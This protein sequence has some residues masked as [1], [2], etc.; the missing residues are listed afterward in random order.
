MIR[1]AVQPQ[2][3][4]RRHGLWVRAAILLLLMYAILQQ[5]GSTLQQYHYSVL[6]LMLPQSQAELQEEHQEHQINENTNEKNRARYDSTLDIPEGSTL[7]MVE[8]R[9]LG[10]FRNQQMRLAGLVV[11]ALQNNHSSI[12]LESIRYDNPVAREQAM[13]D[14]RTDDQISSPSWSNRIQ[15]GRVPME[16][17]LD[18]QHWNR[19]SK[20]VGTHRLP[21]LVRYSLHH[22]G[23]WN[24]QTALFQRLNASLVLASNG[25]TVDWLPIVENCTRPYAFGSGIKAGRLWNTWSLYQRNTRGTD[26]VDGGGDGG[27]QE[28]GFTDLERL[29]AQATHPSH[30]IAAMMEQ[31]LMTTFQEDPIERGNASTSGTIS[32]VLVV[33][34]RTE[35]DMLAHR[36]SKLMTRNLTQI[37]DMI[38]SYPY[39]GGQLQQ[40]NNTNTSMMYFT[41]VYL[42]VSRKFMDPN[43][44]NVGRTVRPLAEHNYQRM[45]Q[46]FQDGLWNGS[47]PVREGGEPLTSSMGLV[48]GHEIHTA[49][50][51]L[52]FFVAVQAHA[53]VGTF[54]S[55]F[56]TD[57]WST[58][59][60]LGK[61][62][63]NFQHNPTT[64]L[65]NVPN[66]GLPP[67]HHC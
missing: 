38:Q 6:E 59:Y 36:C 65:S 17:I 57:V 60:I 64:G 43:A 26:V 2:Q 19:I 15:L 16:S 14:T 4:P 13:N 32:Q 11:Y 9:L 55:S 63:L 42:C 28:V 52:N 1:T 23:D 62:D 31:A 47:V 24:P 50:Q 56:S 33:H 12:L 66:N 10:G 8:P 49:A 18:V 40:S 67:P 48:P 30:T 3:R 20:M 61:G 41:Q 25:R 7:A 34:P 21:R 37:F 54:G 29:L 51:V 53:F 39:F 27:L 22:H 45:L 5:H 58:R 44:P 46:A 35:T